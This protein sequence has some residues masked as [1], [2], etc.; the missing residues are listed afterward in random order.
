MVERSLRMREAQGSIPW[1]SKAMFFACPWLLLILMLI[2][3]RCFQTLSLESLAGF[4]PSLKPT[5][6]KS[7]SK[8]QVYSRFRRDIDQNDIRNKF[9][10][11][12]LSRERR[13]LRPMPTNEKRFSARPISNPAYRTYGI[14]N[15]RALIQRRI[16][17]S[18]GAIRTIK[19]A[20]REIGITFKDLVH[21]QLADH[22]IELKGIR[23]PTGIQLALLEHMK[24]NKGDLMIKAE[25]GSGKSFGYVIAILEYLKKRRAVRREVEV[26]VLG[27]S[28]MLGEQVIAWMRELSPETSVGDSLEDKPTVLVS[29][30]RNDKLRTFLAAGNV[31]QPSLIVV[32][33]TDALLKPLRRFATAKE[34]ECRQKHPNSTLY[35][36]KDL[37]RLNPDSR[38]IYVS[39]T[40]NRMTRNDLKRARLLP[41]GAL[42]LDASAQEET[43]FCPRAISH[44]HI[45]IPAKEEEEDQFQANFLRYLKAISEREKSKK[46]LM[47]LPPSFSKTEMVRMLQENDIECDFL[48]RACAPGNQPN[49]LVGSHTDARGLDIP[50]VAFVVNW[51]VPDS[52]N[53]YLHC[54]GRVGRMGKPGNVYNLLGPDPTDLHR[55]TSF[56]QF[57]RF[58]SQIIC[59]AN[60]K[61]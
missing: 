21:E 53:T 32:D 9:E 14:P 51:G 5:S 60:E 45:F 46:G 35:L 11:G 12:E 38:L 24:S 56:S 4:L 49:L 22:L 42:F 50:E 31:L 47:F 20:V 58:E 36:L 30:G 3:K 28:M 16:E 7:K 33:E 55:Y 15:T 18:E 29:T 40:L 43:M 52:P 19:A 37:R 25:T 1:I 44:H 10:P 41:R 26:L 6:P 59:T 27:P 8:R 48:E 17:T 54:A 23:V 57:L 61:K 39:A 2:A 34:R 13:P